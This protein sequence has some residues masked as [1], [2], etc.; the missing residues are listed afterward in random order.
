MEN[1][2]F[3]DSVTELLQYFGGTVTTTEVT[4]KYAAANI[5]VGLA[6]GDVVLV[7]G[8]AESASNGEKTIATIASDN[9][10]ITVEEAIGT[11]E[12]N[13]AGVTLNQVYYTGWLPAYFYISITGT[14]YCV[15]ANATVTQQFSYDMVTTDMSATA[16]TLT[17]GTGA[18]IT[19]I[20]VPN[21]YWRCRVANVGTADITTMRVYLFGLNP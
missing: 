15:G 13:K 4:N 19:A 3:L 6:V 5:G 16:Q 10:Y 8:M 11:G 18:A 9:S 2:T 21:Y 14:G 12:T 20:S 17:A 1:I 7:A